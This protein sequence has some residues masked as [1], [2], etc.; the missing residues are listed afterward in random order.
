MRKFYLRAILFA[1]VILSMFIQQEVF[2]VIADPDPIEY[3]QPD[4]KVI[5][6]ILKGDEVIN[7]AE[8]LDGY[9]LL[10]NG[11]NG[12][13]YAV[14]NKDGDLVCSGVLAH[15][16]AERTKDE[17][18][19][20]KKLDK[21]LF[22]S[23]KQAEKYKSFSGNYL[24][25]ASS[26]SAFSPNGSKKLLLILIGF[27]DKPF[28][29][30]QADFDGLMNT[31]GYSLN[32]AHGSVKDFFKEI[33]YNKFDLTTDV[34]P[35]V[36]N[37]V[38]NMVYY[39]GDVTNEDGTV[40]HN[41]NAAELI[42]EA[43]LA[44]D[45]DGVDFTQYDNDGD[46]SVDGIYVVY[47]GYGQATSGNADEIWPHA[48]SL[49]PALI[50]DGK[51]VA[52]YSCSNEL[53]AGGTAITTIGVI[54]HEF[55][56]VCG[57]PDYYDTD[58]AIGGQYNGTGKWDLMATGVYCG[59]PSG[60]R[61][62]HFNPNEKYRAG[63]LNPILLT[64]SS[65]I[66][67]PDITTNNVVYKYNTTTP[68]EYFLI[69][70]RQQTG[71]NT[72]IPGH[73]LMIYHYNNYEAS[74]STKNKTHPQGF[75]PVC[76]SATT[77]PTSNP[78]DYGNINSV[79]C[80]FPGSSGKT[81]FDDT[82]TPNSHS[83]AGANS[84]SPISNIVENSG[85]ISFC[86]KGCPVVNPV[87][88]FNGIAVNGSQ[89]NL[90]WTKNTADNDVIIASNTTN[91]FGTLSDGASYEVGNILPGGGTIIYKG[92]A[93]NFYHTG[94][95]SSTI[96]Y[97]QIWALDASLNYS[98]AN[99][100]NATTTCSSITAT[101]FM[102]G[103][104]GRTIP[105]C[106]LQ[107]YVAGT[108]NWQIATSGINSH[109]TSANT[110]TYF[111]RFGFVSSANENFQTKLI[112]PPIDLTQISDPF[113]SFWYVLE[114]WVGRQ[115]ELRVYYRTSVNDNWKLLAEFKSNTSNWTRQSISLPN[116]TSTYY[117]AF[118]GKEVAGYGVCVDDISISPPVAD[119]TSDANIS[120][121]GSLTVNF[122]D[123][124]IGPNGSWA[125]DIDNNGTTDYTTQN[126]THTYSSPG[127]YS[128]K[129]SISN[130]ASTK[131]KENLVLVMNSE[132]TVNTGC[133]LPL[134]SINLNNTAG[135][136]IYRFA[137]GSINNASLCNDG[138][139]Q[140]YT[141]SKWTKLELNKTYNVTIQTG[142]S[143]PEGAKVYID[144]NDN[145]IFD[146]GE[147]VVSFP[148]NK[149][150]TRTLSFT[151]PSSGVILDKG[152]RL[153]VLSK[154]GS[155]PSNACDIS[156]YGQA[157][158]YTV[159]FVS[160]IVGKSSIL[161][162]GN[163]NNPATWSPSGVPVSTDDV[164]ITSPGTV[165]VDVQDAVS[166]NLAVQ[167]GATL[168]ISPSNALTVYGNLAN[169]G[170]L[171]INSDAL[172]QNGS[173]IVNGTSTGNVTYN[174]YLDANRWFIASSPVI[175][176]SGF[177]TLNGSAI[178]PGSGDFDF[179]WYKES[180]NDGWQYY[181]AIPSSLPSGQGYLARLKT[182][183]TNL[184]FTGALQG[185]LSL[186]LLSTLEFDGWNAVGNPYPSALKVQG[187]GGFISSNI[188][189]L[190]PD[191]AALYLWNNTQYDVLSNSGY[192]GA[193]T[194]SGYGSLN[195]P[196]IQ[197]G[198]GFLVN[199]VL[200]GGSVNFLKGTSGMQIH[201]V[202]RTLKSAGISWPG[203]TVM[204]E[205]NEEIRSTIVC[206]NEN[207]TEGLD[208]SYDAGLLSDSD[209][210]IYTN[211]V[212][213]NGNTTN[214]AIQCL[215]E[216][217]YSKWK[218]PLG[219]DIPEAGEY[220]FKVTGVILPNNVYPLLEDRKLE[221]LVSL[222]SETDSYKVNLSSTDEA[223]GRFYLQF[224][225]NSNA[226]EVVGINQMEN[227]VHFTARYNLQRIIIA[228][229]PNSGTKASLYDI[230]GRKV[231][232]EY[233]LSSGANQNEIPAKGLISGVYLL[234]I[235]GN[236]CDQVIKVPVVIVK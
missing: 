108:N 93:A 103:F 213:A 114:A 211:L 224:A 96:Y 133:S 18:K 81:S 161:A 164:T 95:A 99:S 149:V 127:L 50:C 12:W 227:L 8:T 228:G 7:W 60:S 85:V 139:Y 107:E 17:D 65:T 39:G 77:N 25:S 58:Y 79:G 215:P 28:I 51:S 208:V 21:K 153:R 22:Y 10:N 189:T 151:T 42:R 135:I 195:E 54:C 170:A 210:D 119:F 71:F 122:T 1:T 197:A 173:L 176:A 113:L 172:N 41:V 29:K 179:A 207:M 221:K 13:E 158:D 177:N 162:G 141:C 225:D 67:I 231:G 196:T 236:S 216:N 6:I 150:G 63:W 106:W 33:S 219:L 44:A 90:S 53:T 2:A 156:T 40:N 128:V 104:E 203:V 116:P 45:A 118:E 48:G 154:F 199:A 223:S 204:V 202:T 229:T 3:T 235:V 31:P 206:F 169:N 226:P 230:N 82:T 182:G 191:Y 84:N 26:T 19:L 131:T 124:S 73:G 232:G 111:A 163:W 234:R 101:P 126:P 30:T 148:A 11:K 98:T 125:W 92:P 62:S 37:A 146:A 218:V 184:T 80:P 159:Y 97:Y 94:L 193:T 181:T 56:H 32:N 137:L 140:N 166:N 14:L 115:D 24:K 209:F 198:Q 178:N 188:S 187:A 167:N 175:V 64:S 20:I 132:P 220:T 49:S 174:R 91:T 46:G 130:G 117:I 86:F 87:L 194:Y 109:P 36:Y 83:W 160:P 136:G 233:Q 144:Y 142:L 75:Y 192:T 76:A 165:T 112:S 55:G 16:I 102:E 143:N 120:C 180:N 168:L 123:K 4:G 69:E 78:A 15:N 35:H 34:A 190:D 121:N 110:G 52:K 57:A 68:G 171:T 100:T 88:I 185:N 5:T 129:L 105:G 9:T 72:D 157:E 183:S 66:T 145:G 43:V 59:S 70:N 89:I 147:A 74:G 23:T 186:P 212:N 61:P 217:Q 38:N 222:R 201:D 152:L 155:I 205:N 214:F 47:A 134:N 138:Y 27:K 200:G